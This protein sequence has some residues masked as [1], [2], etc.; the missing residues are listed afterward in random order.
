MRT[1]LREQSPIRKAIGEAFG[2]LFPDRPTSF[3]GAIAELLGGHASREQ[4]RNWRRGRAKTP[5]WASQ[6]IAAELHKRIDEMTQAIEAIKKE[7]AAESGPS[8]RY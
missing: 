3:Y 8:I 7:K 1:S 2:A 5:T 6:L 4:I